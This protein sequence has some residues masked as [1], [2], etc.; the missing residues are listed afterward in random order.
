MS[1][2]E[3]PAS[4]GSSASHTLAQRALRTLGS[5]AELSSPPHPTEKKVTAKLVGGTG[6][7]RLWGG[8]TAEST[9]AA[10]MREGERER[11]GKACPWLRPL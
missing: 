3:T 5:P 8:G 6:S 11:E 4:N 9:T 10:D 1:R 2:P 7:W